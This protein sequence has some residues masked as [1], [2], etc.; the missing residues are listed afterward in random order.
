V[1]VKIE[2]VIPGSPTDAFYSQVAMFRLGLDSLGGIYERARLVLCL[3]AENTIAVPAR[4]RRHLARAE[5]LWATAECFRRDGHPGTFRYEVLDASCD[6]SILCDADTFMLRPFDPAHL[7]EFVARPAI[8]G[9]I[10]HYPPPLADDRGRDYNP[11]GQAWFWNFIAAQ[12]IGRPVAFD[13][14]YT[15]SAEPIPCPFYVNYGF[16]IGGFAELRRLSEQLV[17]VM[18]RIREHLANRFVDQLGLA[19]GCA[20]AGIPTESLPMRFNFPND[21]LADAR[22]PQELDA[23]ILVHYL[24]LDRYDRHEI[25]TS[26]AGFQ[27]FLSLDLTGSNRMFQQRVHEITAGV[28]P[29]S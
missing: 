27:R 28:Y 22:Y 13:Y 1:F 5:V 23:A 18:P 9:V 19:L 11:R 7:Q 6:L 2:F 3:G 10:A 12:A 16:V 26:A 25:F 4:W 21:P 15:L 29:F 8:R 14:C 20:A 24:R 17:D